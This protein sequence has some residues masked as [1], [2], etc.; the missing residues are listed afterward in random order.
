MQLS[1]RLSAVA[2]MVTEGNRLVDVGCDHGYL[3]VYL[4]LEKKIP[5]AIAMDVRKGP[6]SRAKEHIGE[7]GLGEYIE[8]R[9]SDGLEALKE[10]EGDTLVMAGMGGL[11]MERILMDGEGVLKGFQ[12]L[13]LQPQSDL[14][15]FRRFLLDSGWVIVEEDIVLEDGKFYPMMKAVSAEQVR[16]G[17]CKKHLTYLTA[18]D[19]EEEWF[20]KLLLAGKHP[21]LY[22]YL[23]REDRIRRDIRDRLLLSPGEGSRKR[24]TEIEEE[25]R[26]IQ[27]A[28]SRYEGKRTDSVSGIP[29]SGG[30]CGKLG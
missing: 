17:T 4:V 22:E 28:L 24:M 3:P 27:A 23:L 21:V 11:L 16:R 9:L 20:G 15:H 26:L 30:S 2:G 10:G 1:L 19:P 12:E 5:G 6:L 25:R 14:R 18:Y 13:I 29:V 7:Y 8:T